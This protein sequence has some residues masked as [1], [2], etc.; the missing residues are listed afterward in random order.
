LFLAGEFTAMPRV[1]VM[2]PARSQ[3]DFKT[4]AYWNHAALA[5]TVSQIQRSQIMRIESLA[6]FVT[7]VDFHASFPR[8]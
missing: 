7:L 3:T 1:R 8:P 6:E 2:S 4:L 5:T